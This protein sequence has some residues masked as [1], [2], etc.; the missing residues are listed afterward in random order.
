MVDSLPGFPE[1]RSTLEAVDIVCGTLQAKL[2]TKELS[3]GTSRCVRLNGDLLT[4]CDLQRKAGKASSKNWKTTI[5][6][7]DQP[8]SK[9]LVSY[10]DEMGR[11]RCRFEPNATLQASSRASLDPQSSILREESPSSVAQV[12]EEEEPN[13]PCLTS[14]NSNDI[15]LNNSSG[16]DLPDFQPVVQP[17]F[18]WGDLDG[19]CFISELDKVYLEVIHWK[20]NSF[21]VPR[22]SAGKA[23]VLELARLFRAVGE[24][25]SLESVA[26]KEIV[27]VCI[28][29][30]QKPSRTS[31]DK[32]HTLLLEQR[33]K[34]WKDGNLLELVTEGGAIQGRLK[35]HL[36]KLSE[37]QL[38]RNFSKLM[39]EGKTKAALRL[40]SGYQRG[41]VLNL[42]EI[43]D[44]ASPGHCVRD[45][46]RAK[47]PPAQPLDPKCLL[48][49]WADPPSVHPVIFSSLNAAVIRSAALRTSG[50]AGPSGIDARGW[51]RLCTSFHSASDLL[52]P[53]LVCRLIALDKNPGVRPIG[54]CEVMRRIVAK[55]VLVIL[56]DDIQ[57]AAGSHQLCAGQLSGAEAAVHAV[58]KVFE[59]GS[60]EAV[61][62][63]DASNAFNSLNRLVALHNIRQLCPPLST[64]LINI[65][66]SPASLLVSGEVILSEE[67]TTQGDPLAMPMYA[68]ATVPLINQLHGTVDQVWYADDACACG[69]I[70]DLLIWWNQLCI[71]GPAFG[72]FVNAPKTWLVSKE[73]F[74]SIATTLFSDTD[75]QI[76]SAGRPYLGAAIGSNAYV[77]EFVRDKVVG[78]SAEITRLAKFAQVQPHAAYSA[79]T[80]GL[81]SHWLYLCRTT[82]NISEALQPLE[83]NI[84]LVLIPTLMG[85]SP[86]NDTIRKLFALP[87][88]YGG[89]GIINPTL[90]A[91][92]LKIRC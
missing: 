30:L 47:H 43:A 77:Q 60:T 61:L 54:V 53:F 8:I 18:Q 45:V 34:Q 28:L 44:S 59:E 49:H 79:L 80:H 41:G 84:R 55:A 86:P 2:I 36:P 78:W 74:H 66:R 26:L 5:R 13:A 90:I 72:Y 65:Y 63:V 27:V 85:C 51:R 6:Y 69:S 75:V 71:K 38:V 12:D 46:L 76:T 81:S 29:L 21:A 64:I 32:D 10:R 39:F 7:Q 3:S 22:G 37:A 23:F 16:V 88:R 40:V 68:L 83:D 9:F 35:S 62:L 17:N 67:G 70:Q 92:S 20:K 42:D 31:K 50:A 14:N 48:Q 89:L 25:S 52:S 57:E 11:R 87:P 82:P 73:R 1:S 58:R 19:S 24:G 15:L 4:P 33:L 56:R 91:S